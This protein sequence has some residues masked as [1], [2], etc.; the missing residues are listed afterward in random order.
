MV[1]EVGQDAAREVAGSIDA[2]REMTERVVASRAETVF[3]ISP[4]APL[5]AHAFVA[6][7]DAELRGGFAHFRAPQA[8]VSAPLDAGLLDVLERAA[9]EEGFELAPL[10][11][12]EL[13]HGTAVPLYFLLRNGWRGRLVALGYS[14]RSDSDHLRFGACVR[15]AAD[16]AGRT[17]AF[18]A[19][20]DLSHRLTRGAPAGYN[21]DAHLFDEQVVA[22]IRAS[23]PARIAEIDPNL[24]RLAGECGYRSMLVAVGAADGLR[25]DCE[26]MHYEAPFGVGYMVAQLARGGATAETKEFSKS[27]DEAAASTKTVARDVV[28]RSPDK[29]NAARISTGDGEDSRDGVVES[30]PALA[31]RAVETYVREGRVLR[32]ADAPSS[33]LF[34]QPAACFVSI[35][36]EDGELRGCIGTVEP[37]QDSL[38]E[39]LAANAV[40]AATRDPRFPPVA[41]DELPHLRYS[42]D[43][44]SEPEPARFED[45]D[46][47]NYGVIV[48]DEAGVRRG[49]LLPDIEGIENADQQVQIAARKAGI[50]PDE[51]VRLYRF[52]VSRFRESSSSNETTE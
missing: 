3:I 49:L 35:K 32:S 10:E 43:I 24:R 6:Y 25:A 13:D 47:K 11:G 30:L 50:A 48:E 40:S 9:A 27:E 37:T 21:P 2:M 16:A 51:P 23:A 28:G 4:H 5:E 12:Y 38:A 7:R 44:L 34:D 14:F 45:L 31:R 46:P 36:T 1:P 41:L 26:V 19:S 52:R 33:A 39:E 20:G 8:T 29:E 15:R 17:V 22:S 18:V 42:V